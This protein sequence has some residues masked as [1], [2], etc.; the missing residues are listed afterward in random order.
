MSRQGFE[1]LLRIIE[2]P[3]SNLCLTPA[4]LTAVFR[5]LLALERLGMESIW[6]KEGD[7]VN[8]W[9]EVKGVWILRDKT[10]K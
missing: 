7:N 10:W 6:N 2:I 4:V 5:G 8:V 9:K 1:L 3:G